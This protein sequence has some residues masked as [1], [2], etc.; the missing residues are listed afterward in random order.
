METEPAPQG[1]R[2]DGDVGS[3][4]GCITSF[5]LGRLE[6]GAKVAIAYDPDDPQSADLAEPWRL[7]SGP[8]VATLLYAAVVYYAFLA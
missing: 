2:A 5:D 7:Y 1:C 6:V 8:V 3:G 4:G